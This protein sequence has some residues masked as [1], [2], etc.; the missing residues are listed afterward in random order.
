MASIDFMALYLLVVVDHW[1]EET[2]SKRLLVRS[3]RTAKKRFQERK[4]DLV[5]KRT[6]MLL[7]EAFPSQQE[8]VARNQASR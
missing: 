7:Y 2:G 1:T 6:L 4:Q 3:S 8:E 5:Q